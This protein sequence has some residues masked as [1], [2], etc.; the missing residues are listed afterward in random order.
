MTYLREKKNKSPIADANQIT[1]LISG[2][3]IRR[4]IYETTTHTKKVNS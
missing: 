1:C 2:I 4:T 3:I